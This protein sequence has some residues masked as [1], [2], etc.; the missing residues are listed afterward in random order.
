M[1]KAPW[2]FTRFLPKAQRVLLRGRLPS[3]L[4]AVASKSAHQGGRLGKLREDL[5]LLQVLCLAYWRGEYRAISVK[6]MVT[7]V[8]GLMYF[9]SPID[10]IPDFIPVFGMLDDIAVLAWVMNTLD[11]E[12]TAFRHWLELQAPEQLRAIEHLP[13]TPEQLQLQRHEKD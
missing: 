11:Q 13:D 6:S 4:F 1:M 10:A 9:L 7:V 2:S 5:K 8:A 12:L 3:L